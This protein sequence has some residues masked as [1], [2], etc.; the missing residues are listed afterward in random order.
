M[1]SLRS[2]WGAPEGTK[3][4][5]RGLIPRGLQEGPER[6]M[7]MCFGNPHG[8]SPLEAPRGS[9]K[10]PRR[11]AMGPREGSKGPCE[12]FYGQFKSPKATQTGWICFSHDGSSWGPAGALLGPLG[13]GP[14]GA[15]LLTSWPFLGV[16]RGP[17]QGSKRALSS[18][19]A[20][21]GP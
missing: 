1:E 11:G 6:C 5:P 13:A 16:P 2:F 7:I 20:P 4:A 14:L 21:R 17:S 12:G 10:A 19:W 8:A 3:R 15:A 9:Q 18:K